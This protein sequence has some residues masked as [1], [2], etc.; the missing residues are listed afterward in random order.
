[1][2]LNAR[3]SLETPERNQQKAKIQTVD[4]TFFHHDHPSLLTLNPINGILPLFK[5]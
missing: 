2:I 3:I 5:I 4:Q 1:M